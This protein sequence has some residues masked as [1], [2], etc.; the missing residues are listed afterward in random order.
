[1]GVRFLY[2][3]CGLAAMVGVALFVRSARLDRVSGRQRAALVAA[4]ILVLQFGYFH[5]DYFSDYRWRLIHAS[6]LLAAVV[7]AAWLANTL[8]RTR[9]ALG[10]LTAVALLG[11]VS[12]QFAYFY[13]DYLTQYRV[14]SGNLEPEGNGRAAWE[15]VI[16]RARLRSVPAVYLGS[17]GPYGF[18]DLYWKFYTIKH[19]REDLLTRTVADVAFEPARVRNLPDMSL[20]VTSPSPETDHAIERMLA[21]GEIRDKTL[22][23]APDGASRFWILETSAR[24]PMTDR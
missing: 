18:G 2:A 23:T 17:V 11:V 22:V 10:Q 8:G 5:I 3:S 24:T 1:M 21:A 6:G 9:V 19:H 16:A 15:T 12:I 14:R 13:V 4:G 7:A 20:A